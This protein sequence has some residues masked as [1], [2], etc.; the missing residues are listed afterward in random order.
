MILQNWCLIL[1]A[2][3]I[4]IYDA[5]LEAVI[6]GDTEVNVKDLSNRMKSLEQINPETNK[7]LLEEEFEVSSSPLFFYS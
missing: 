7:T 4:F 3:Y 6:C 5:L 1:Q 2:Q